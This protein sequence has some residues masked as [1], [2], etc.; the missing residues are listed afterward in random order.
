MSLSVVSVP[1]KAIRFR[2]NDAQ[3]SSSIE[4]WTQFTHLALRLSDRDLGR[5]TIDLGATTRFLCSYLEEV[6]R[7]QKDSLSDESR[8][9]VPARQLLQN[10]FRLVVRMLSSA[11]EI[12][13]ALC[14][15]AHLSQFV[16]VY[17]GGNHAVVD[18]VLE[19]VYRRRQDDWNSVLSEDYIC[20]NPIIVA[21]L[22][23]TCSELPASI[24][25]AQLAR[26]LIAAYEVGRSERLVLRRLAMVIATNKQC[27]IKFLDVLLSSNQKNSLIQDLLNRTT[28]LDRIQSASDGRHGVQNLLSNFME[29]QMSSIERTHAEAATHDEKED[30]A[31]ELMSKISQLQDLFPDMNA[32]WLKACLLEY[33]NDVT[34][35]TMQI[36]EDK[37]PERLKVSADQLNE[38]APTSKQTTQPAALSRSN[39]SFPERANIF[40]GDDF[41]RLEHDRS[42]VKDRRRRR[43]SDNADTML[44]QTL[45]LEEQ[46]KVL[47]LAYDPN[48]DEFDDTYD[49]YE[50]IPALDHQTND[51]LADSTSLAVPSIDDLL[52][53]TSESNPGVFE[54]SARK[55]K[56]REDL[57]ARTNLSDEQIEGWMVMLKREPARARKL[58]EKHAFAG[59]QAEIKSSKWSPSDSTDDA[60]S[61]KADR[62]RGRGGGRPPSRGQGTSQRRQQTQPL[63]EKSAEQ[64]KRE[65]A[66]KEVRGSGRGRGRGGGMRGQARPQG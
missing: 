1:S 62:S 41:D 57:R 54:R 20:A 50:R 44:K 49:D 40:D 26:R 4:T 7:E 60:D 34:I 43:D 12:P 42:Q 25:S 56:D 6:S 39:E 9:L 3:W 55:Q 15:L 45:S 11:E 53:M 61:P 5:D 35:T 10:V 31:F 48:E 29:V 52:F 17:R 2:L 64:V 32:M 58:A 33:D 59:Q 38:L 22:C 13:T 14:S 37:L 30:E 24:A 21:N 51:D 18:R 65:R 36:L 8:R 16:A 28:F 19:A 46:A 63:G 47:S 23:S 27:P 66:K